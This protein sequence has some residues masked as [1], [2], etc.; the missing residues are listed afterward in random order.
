MTIFC[1]LLPITGLTDS[2]MLSSRDVAAKP[3]PRTVES[4]NGRVR[5]RV[6]DRYFAAAYYERGS[7]AKRMQSSTNGFEQKVWQSLAPSYIHFPY[8]PDNT[9][10]PQGNL[11]ATTDYQE[12][13]IRLLYDYPRLR[14]KQYL[15][16][17]H[18]LLRVNP[19]DYRLLVA[20]TNACYFVDSDGPGAAYSYAARARA[21]R[22]NDPMTTRLMAKV[23]YL[24]IRYGVGDIKLNYDQFKYWEKKVEA[25]CN[26]S[27]SPES[28][29]DRVT[30]RS[31]SK[32]LA[33]IVA[34]LDKKQSG[35]NGG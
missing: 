16:L 21:I 30:L 10:A 27:N 12:L 19:G 9:S 4:E 7:L 3:D 33:E 22:P 32:S 11:S 31:H 14:A 17:L 28:L 35:K 15:V 5:K 34:D 29:D 8:D 25:I 24:N 2:W 23:Y 18:N 1:L 26:T 20:A 6:E 13:A